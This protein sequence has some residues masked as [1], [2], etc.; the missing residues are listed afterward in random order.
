V[1]ALDNVLSSKQ[2]ISAP[3]IDNFMDFTDE[4]VKD[5][6]E[7]DSRPASKV[8]VTDIIKELERRIS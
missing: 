5:N 2:L 8:K 6:L 7:S 4:E 3:M 1:T